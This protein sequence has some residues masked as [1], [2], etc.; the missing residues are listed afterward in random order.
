MPRKLRLAPVALVIALVASGC[1]SS[2][3]APT[4]Q[5]FVA[6]ADPI[7]KQVSIVRNSANAA[8][9]N[10]SPSTTK[11]LSVLARVAPSVASDEQQA[12]AKLRTLAPP[13]SLSGDW[14]AL[15]TGMQQLAGDAAQIAADAKSDKFEAVKSITDSGRQLRQQLT[16]IASRDG[17]V[18]CGRTS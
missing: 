10:V 14:H 18:Y 15:L 12:V 13:S 5:S 7:C 11:E 6:Q 17:F 3:S 4:R 8:V 9:N 1:G 16:A 2:G